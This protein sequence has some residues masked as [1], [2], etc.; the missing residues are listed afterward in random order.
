MQIIAKKLFIKCITEVSSVNNAVVLTTAPLYEV[1]G[2]VFV[3]YTLYLKVF[4][5][6]TLYLN[7]DGL[8]C[9]VCMLLCMAP[10]FAVLPGVLMYVFIH[11]GVN[12]LNSVPYRC[13][14]YV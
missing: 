14:T 10:S 1:F 2:T 6:Y 13:Y 11:G 3:P 4:F 7:W 5:P 12:C 9:A 8:V